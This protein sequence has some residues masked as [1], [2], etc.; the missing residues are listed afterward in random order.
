MIKNFN[1][2]LQHHHE[3]AGTDN[4]A[5]ASLDISEEQALEMFFVF[6]F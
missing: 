4:S 6:I 3:E 5:T 1:R 2:A